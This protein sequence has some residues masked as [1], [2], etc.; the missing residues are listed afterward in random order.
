MRLNGTDLGF[1]RRPTPTPGV[2]QRVTLWGVL[3]AAAVLAFAVGFWALLLLVHWRWAL[4]ELSAG[5]GLFAA[6][7][8]GMERRCRSRS[9]RS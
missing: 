9:C 4:V 7:V 2:V 1:G 8:F 6:V 3:V 5:V